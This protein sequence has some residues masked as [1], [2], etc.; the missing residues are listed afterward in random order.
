MTIPSTFNS[1]VSNIRAGSQASRAMIDAAPADQRPFLEAQQQMQQDAQIVSLV[2][3]L[4]KKLDDMAT[5]V[6]QNLK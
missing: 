1:A 6:I 3:N 5:G 2:T 4:M